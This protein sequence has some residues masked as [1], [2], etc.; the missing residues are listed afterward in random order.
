[1]A[2]QS[3][4]KVANPNLLK[5]F[6][7]WLTKIIVTGREYKVRC[8]LVTQSP[9]LKDC[10]FESSGLRDNLSICAQGR[11]G[12]KRDVGYFAITKCLDNEAIVS[13][14]QSEPLRAELERMKMAAEQAGDIPIMLTTQG[15][16]RL[17]LLPNLAGVERV[18]YAAEQ[19]DL[20]DELSAEFED[21]SDAET[22]DPSVVDDAW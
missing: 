3:E 14:A 8:I 21:E 2:L 22:V 11:M 19:P 18:L 1:M 9:I 16:P 4:L 10:G 20:G 5:Q 13:R 15:T 7:V 6:L 12:A 17:A